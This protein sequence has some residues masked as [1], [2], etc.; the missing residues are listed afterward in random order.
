MERALLIGMAWLGM[1]C[2]TAPG[3]GTAPDPSAPNPLRPPR[4]PADAPGGVPR[5]NLLEGTMDEKLK[6]ALTPMLIKHKVPALAVAVFDRE[7]I[8]GRAASG[9]RARGGPDSVTTAD[10]WHIGSCTKAMTATVVGGLVDRGLLTWETTLAEALPEHAERMHADLKKVTLR[11]LLRH[12]AGLA[13]FTAG[14]SPDFEMLKG[15]PGKDVREQRSAFVGALLSM[16]PVTPPDTK[17]FYSNAGYAVAAAA[18]ERAADKGYEALLQEFVF[19]RLALTHAG[20]GWPATPTRRDEPRGHLPGILGVKAQDFDPKYKLEPVLAPAGD[21]HCTVEELATFARAHLD[22]LMEH[23]SPSKP[24]KHAGPFV[25]KPAT[26]AELH[27][28]VDGYA[29]GWAVD[30]IQGEVRHWH[31]GS[32]GTFFALAVIVPGRGIGAVAVC[33]SG[34]GER[35]CVELVETGLGL[36]E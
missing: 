28:P 36:M 9:L 22:A 7:G 32:A 10:R 25:V 8:R 17:E 6:G 30:T 23:M 24:G 27:D 5:T 3:Q 4:T 29:G 19:N 34:D 2:G 35:A 16:A 26:A 15:L 21:V 33:N 14:N 11:Q 13:A 18:A 20:L 31:N 1:A 12:R